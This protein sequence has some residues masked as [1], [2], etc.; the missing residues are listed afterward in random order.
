M[1]ASVSSAMVIVI[2]FSVDYVCH[3]AAHYVHSVESKRYERATESVR[4][5][6]VSILSGA[7]TTV[8]S[9]LFLFGGKVAFFET[10]AV[11][12]SSTVA[13]SITFA[14]FFF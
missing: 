9:G 7:I 11:A 13:L 4:D 14:L 8:G 1:G 10:F 2:G 6:G 12:I 3:L 5:M